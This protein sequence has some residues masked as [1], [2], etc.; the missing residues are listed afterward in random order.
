MV[1]QAT[2]E[3][4]KSRCENIEKELRSN[5]VRGRVETVERTERGELGENP[6]VFVDDGS[7]V[8]RVEIWKGYFDHGVDGQ[9][10]VRRHQGQMH[11]DGISDKGLHVPNVGG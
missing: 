10:V 4:T 8:P 7:G 1:V 11:A 5:N 6:S 3:W 9:V 2:S